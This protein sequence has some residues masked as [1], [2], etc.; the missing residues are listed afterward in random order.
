MTGPHS[1]A[2]PLGPLAKA[3]QTSACSSQSYPDLEGYGD[4]SSSAWKEV[5]A[6]TEQIRATNKEGLTLLRDIDPRP[7]VVAWQNGYRTFLPWLPSD[8][9]QV[10]N[11]RAKVSLCFLFCA[12][13]GKVK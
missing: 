2:L 4:L 13:D 11:A 12:L 7:G 1:Q 3:D 10:E 9:P 6:K 5:E 8:D